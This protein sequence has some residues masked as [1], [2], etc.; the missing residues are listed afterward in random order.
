VHNRGFKRFA[1]SEAPECYLV[2]T[3]YSRSGTA[4]RGSGYLRFERETLL[5][6]AAPGGKLSHPYIFQVAAR[7]LGHTLLRHPDR[8]AW[9]SLPADSGFYIHT[10]HTINRPSTAAAVV[11]R[12]VR[13]GEDP[14]NATMWV[15]LGEPVTSVAIPLWVNAGDTPPAIRYGTVCKEA[16]RLKWLARPFAVSEK[17]EYLDLA[18]LDNKSGTGWLPKLLAEEDKIFGETERLLSRSS[19]PAER[20][21]FQQSISERVLSLLRSIP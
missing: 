18:R 1:A 14:A 10:N 8:A 20:A 9:K 21:S 16:M 11:I 4:N 2:N 19:T 6:H 15:L 12:G 3:N 13:K 17:R 7:D 5:L